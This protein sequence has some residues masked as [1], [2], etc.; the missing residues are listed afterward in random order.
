MMYVIGVGKKEV[1]LKEG[2]MVE[3]VGEGREK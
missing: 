3:V 1:E 2:G